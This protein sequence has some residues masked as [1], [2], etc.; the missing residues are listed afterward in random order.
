MYEVLRKHI[1]DF[2]FNHSEISRRA[3]NLNQA[4]AYRVV[5]GETQNPSISSITSI[6]EAVSLTDADAGVLYRKVGYSSAKPR[7]LSLHESQLEFSL[8]LI[9]I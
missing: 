7:L 1:Q 2:G 3:T 9:H 6:I 5:E 4:T 8:S